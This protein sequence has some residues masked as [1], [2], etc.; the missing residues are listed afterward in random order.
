M[1]LVAT[2]LSEEAAYALEWTIGTVL[3]D[4]DTLLAV[5]AVDEEAGTGEANNS[6]AVGEGANTMKDVAAIVRTLSNQDALTVPAV[7]PHGKSGS[8]AGVSHSD[9]RNEQAPDIRKMDKAER[10]RYRATEE[11]TDRCIKLLRKTKLQVRVVVEVFHCKSPKHMITEVI[12]YLAPTLVILGSRGRSALKGVLLGSFSNYLVTKSS[13]PVMV[14]RKKLR[15]HSKLKR[16]NLRLSNMLQYPSGRRL[17]MANIE[18]PSKGSFK[19]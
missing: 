9:E 19:A 7:R 14:A 2:D 5:Y 18:K 10:E 11:I 8:D 3:R 12:D 16:G 17:E 6:I 15:K 4:G 13:V 1:Y